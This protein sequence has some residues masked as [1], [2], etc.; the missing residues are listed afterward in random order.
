MMPIRWR[1]TLLVAT[2]LAAPL[3]QAAAQE[4][5][6]IRQGRTLIEAGRAREAR[7]ML[8]PFAERE[9]RDGAAAF[10]TGRAFLAEGERKEAERW[11]ERAL[12]RAPAQ[13]DYHY[14]A[15]VATAERVQRAG[16]VTAMRR[17]GRIRERFER[18][19][20]LDPRHVAAREGLVDY[21]L[22]APA[23]AGGSK[24]K[25]GENARLLATIDVAAGHRATASIRLV[26][27]DSMGAIAALR[28]AIA[29]EPGRRE[30]RMTLGLGLQSMARWDEALATFD[31][32]LAHDPRDLAALYQVGRTAALSGK[33]LAKGEAAL[34]A[35]VAAPVSPDRPAHAAAWW[36]LG[37]VLRHQG[38]TADA[39]AAR[40]RAVG[41]SCSGVAAGEGG[42]GGAS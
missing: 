37:Q 31:S 19:V 7:Q 42:A 24:E 39:R 28:S 9:P 1:R 34:R 20:A 26:A 10:W 15:G 38:R 41:A 33:Y 2:P 13:A 25:A 4:P 32:A 5:A 29:V 30:T 21:Y 8:Q 17:A 27:G 40:Y 35:Y 14:W 12:E 18:A 3:R 36:R 22:N 6:E 11:L 16:V 23:V